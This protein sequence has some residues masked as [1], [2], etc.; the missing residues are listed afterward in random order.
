M[1]V[2]WNN[3]TVCKQMTITETILLL[4]L[5]KNTWNH[6]TVCKKKNVVETTIQKFIY[7]CPMNAIAKHLGIK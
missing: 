7:K 2:I 4:V 1:L 6:I 5:D 3:M